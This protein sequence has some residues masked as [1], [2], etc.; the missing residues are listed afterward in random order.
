MHLT[1]AGSIQIAKR[2][3]KGFSAEPISDLPL[4]D[5]RFPGGP[6]SLFSQRSGVMSVHFFNTYWLLGDGAD[7]E[8]KRWIAHDERKKIVYSSPKAVELAEDGNYLSPQ[9]PIPPQGFVVVVISDNEVEQRGV[10][11]GVASWGGEGGWIE[12]EEL[13]SDQPEMP[14]KAESIQSERPEPGKG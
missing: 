10:T 3:G 9:L 2:F 7:E 5:N 4:W 8:A 11:L 13:T 1:A 14:E 6:R 12:P